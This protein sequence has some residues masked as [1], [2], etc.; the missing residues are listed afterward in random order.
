MVVAA[1]CSYIYIYIFYLVSTHF[2]MNFDLRCKYFC[3]LAAKH[4]EMLEYAANVDLVYYLTK[5]NNDRSI[6]YSWVS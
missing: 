3:W 2:V 4:K 1:K 5:D 6:N